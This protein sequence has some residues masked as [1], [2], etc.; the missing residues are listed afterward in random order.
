MI[1]IDYTVIK[2]VTLQATTVAYYRGHRRMFSTDR[3][4]NLKA[5][6]TTNVN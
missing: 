6:R 3:K 5:Y 4:T 2:V 1:M